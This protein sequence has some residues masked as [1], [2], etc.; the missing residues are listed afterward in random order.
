MASGSGVAVFQGNEED[1]PEGSVVTASGRVSVAEQFREPDR[2][3]LPFSPVQLTR[4]DDALTLTSRETGLRFAL[5]LGDLGSDARATAVDLHGRIEGYDDAVL[6]AV[7]PGQRLLEIVTGAEAAV[8]LTDRGAKL[9]LMSMVA[10]FKEGDLFGGLLSGLRM[11]ADQAGT[12][13]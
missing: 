8:R 1:L 6:V 3:D 2:S 4:L 11:L 10:S 13:G 9:A 12:R 5:Y 7:S